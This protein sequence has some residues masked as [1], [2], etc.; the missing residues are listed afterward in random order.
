M[1]E[2]T[3]IEGLRNEM[4]EEIRKIER[5]MKGEMDEMVKILNGNIVGDWPRDDEGSNLG[6]RSRQGRFCKNL[7]GGASRPAIVKE[8]LL[9]G[10]RAVSV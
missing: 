9:R 4:K 7:G 10:G 6:T 1:K 2:A 5:E 3:S 8:A